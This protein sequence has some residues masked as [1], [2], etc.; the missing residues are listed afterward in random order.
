MD[1]YADISEAS[2]VPAKVEDDEETSLAMLDA[3]AML[4]INRY[5]CAVAANPAPPLRASM[6]QENMLGLMQQVFDRLESPGAEDMSS[7]EELMA[8]LCNIMLDPVKFAAGNVTRH[9]VAWQLLFD[10]LG[11]S[12]RSRQVLHWMEHG[13]LLEFVD[14]FSPGQ[15][16]HPRY[17]SKLKL[18]EQLLCDTAGRRQFM[19]CCIGTPQHMCSLQIGCPV[20]CTSRL[21]MIQFKS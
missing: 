21:W 3:Q 4:P 19:A 7:D 5:P 2:P 9:L 12:K 15:E 8:Y 17:H 13:V 20:A 14:P 11:H 1:W 18:V 10:K 6:T 16:H